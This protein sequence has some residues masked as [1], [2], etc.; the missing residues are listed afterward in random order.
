MQ[1][2]RRRCHFSALN[3]SRRPPPLSESQFHLEIITGRPPV[4]LPYLEAEFWKRYPDMPGSEFARF[5]D[6][7]RKGR[8]F[9]GGMMIA[10]EGKLPPEYAAALRAQQ[11][12]DLERSLEYCKRT[13]GVGVAW[14]A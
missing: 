1:T 2:H 6:L 8:P 5:V 4:V 12:H 11:R 10:G 3:P 14:R 9:A 13:L 7:A